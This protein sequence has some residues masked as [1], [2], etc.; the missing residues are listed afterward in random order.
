MTDGNHDEGTRPRYRALGVRDLSR[1]AARAGATDY[2]IARMEAVATVLPFRV[3]EYVIEHLID[4]SAGTADPIFRLVFPD[5][6][7][8]DPAV[9]ERI[10]SLRKEPESRDEL[11]LLVSTV[12]RSLNPHPGAQLTLNTPSKNS[13]PSSGIQHKYPETI[14][15][16]PR[17]AQSCHAY[18]SYCFRW[19]Q[20]TDE[21]QLRFASSDIDSL[22]SYIHGHPQVT[23]VLLTG[24]DP[25]MMSAALLGQYIDPLLTIPQL[26]S[27]RIGTKS[28]SYWPHRFTTDP[29]SRELL[30]LFKRVRDSDRSLSLMAHISHPIQLSTSVAVDAVH[31]ITET[32]AT[33]RS[34]TPMIRGINDSADTWIQMIRRQIRLGVVPY[35][36]FIER[37]TGPQHLYSV[38]LHK[39]LEIFR[40]AYRS[41]SGLGR[42][43]RG[44]V[45]STTEGKVLIEDV[46]EHEG[47][48]VF[49]LSYIQC[50]NPSLVGLKLFA[51]F[52]PDAV[53][54]TDLDFLPGQP[55]P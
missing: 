27:I 7:A 44:P 36:M 35:Y 10:I 16:F 23:N 47:E 51:R 3:N 4:W 41:V 18:C 25:M 15:F 34:Q 20:F 37:D 5:A 55:R 53:W 30:D 40:Q 29:D 48:K 42:T 8:I 24:G 19:P 13:D 1:L 52:N 14:L 38:P 6:D 39:A 49:V 31:A 33:I 54:L 21:D 17:Q 32:G 45:M 11:K 12:R 9:A 2:Q 22:V 50:R 28:I 46:V 26:E 43:L